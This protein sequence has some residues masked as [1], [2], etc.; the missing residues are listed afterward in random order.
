MLQRMSEYRV[1]LYTITSFA[2]WFIIPF[3]TSD[4]TIIVSTGTNVDT[5]EIGS[6]Y[7]LNC[8]VIGAEKLT[9]STITYQWFKDG[10][11]VSEEVTETFTSTSL[12]FLNA[13][14]YTCQATVVSSLLDEQIVSSLSPVVGVPLTCELFSLVTV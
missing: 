5:P 11:V 10:E 1:S 4:P 12:S 2:Q 8:T 9:D 13:G 6:I 14:E 7:T 3:F